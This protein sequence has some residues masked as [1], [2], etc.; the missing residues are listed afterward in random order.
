MIKGEKNTILVDA[1][2]TAKTIV[3]HLAELDVAPSD[4]DGIIITHEHSDHIGGV[5]VLS[6]NYSIPVY[7]NEK[8]KQRLMKQIA[9]KW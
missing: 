9:D 4:I 8:T 2:L 5:N 7:A 1:G 6:K 3:K